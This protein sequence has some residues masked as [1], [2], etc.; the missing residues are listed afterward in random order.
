MLRSR[1]LSIL[2]EPFTIAVRFAT[3]GYEAFRWSP[4]SIQSTI[5]AY[6]SRPIA[7]TVATAAITEC[8]APRHSIGTQTGI[9][10][11]PVSLPLVK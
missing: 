4:C 2:I 9:P 6:S 1:K 11:I 3:A 8:S 7:R 10:L 5:K